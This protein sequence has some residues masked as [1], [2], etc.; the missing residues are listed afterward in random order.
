MFWAASGW[1]TYHTPSTPSNGGAMIKVLLLLAILAAILIPCFLIYYGSKV[2]VRHSRQRF[3]A[4]YSPELLEHED[5]DPKIIRLLIEQKREIDAAHGSVNEVQG[6]IT[7]L[8]IKPDSYELGEF[9]EPL[10][11]WLDNQVKGTLE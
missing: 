3:M 10:R 11:K 7:Q 5:L 2:L 6:L 8:L 9:H 4:Q 1:K